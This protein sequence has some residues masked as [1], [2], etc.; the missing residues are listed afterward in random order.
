MYENL[1]VI[2]ELVEQLGGKASIEALKNAIE[3]EN[4]GKHF[5]IP[6]EFCVILDAG[7][8]GIDPKTGRYTTAPSKMWTHKAT[9]TEEEFTFYEG[10]F[11]R[12]VC[13]LLEE[14]LLRRGIPVHR[15]YHSHQDV[16]LGK[17]ANITN[18]IADEHS[19]AVLISIHGNAAANEKAQGLEVFTS[20]GQTKSDVLAEHLINCLA[21]ELPE[22]KMRK[23]TTDGDQDKEANFYMLRKTKCPAVLSEN[24]FFTN[25]AEAK[26]MLSKDYQFKIAR[27]HF[28]AVL[29][30]LGL[31]S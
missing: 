2:L 26:K 22:M 9:A 5:D 24:G 7:H 13:E 17:R 11:N 15:T 8:G 14:M 28:C 27:A 1:K 21:Q 12:E 6:L 10:V 31:E 18:N 4:A 20:K 3:S 30:Y 23:D 29:R 16:S 25:R 19:K